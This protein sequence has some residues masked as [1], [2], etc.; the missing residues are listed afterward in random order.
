MPSFMESACEAKP[1]LAGGKRWWVGC[2]QAWLWSSTWDFRKT[3][4]PRKLPV[5]CVFRKRKSLILESRIEE[6]LLVE[7][8]I[9][10]RDPFNQNYRKISVQN[11]MDRF[12]PTGKVSKKQVHLLRWS[13]FPGR[14]AL[15]FGWMDR[16]PGLWN[17]RIPRHPANDGI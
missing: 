8:R 7:S 16:A 14:T 11:S 3:I 13:S 12:G 4:R 6:I 5:F 9:L 10:G 1:K 15:N 2:L 17:L